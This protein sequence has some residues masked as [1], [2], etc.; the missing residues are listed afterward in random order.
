MIRSR[1]ALLLLVLAFSLPAMAEKPDH[2]GKPSHKHGDSKASHGVDVSLVFSSHERDVVRGYHVEH[3]GKGGCPPGLAKKHNGCLPPGQAKKRYEIGRPLPPDFVIMDLPGD[4]SIR[5][6]LPSDGY[7][8]GMIDGDVVKLVVGSL[9][10]V[11]AI[12]AHEN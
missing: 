3:Y 6:G 10:V 8:Y 12:G 11:D 5:L 4:L 2:A 1:L 9:L 7:R